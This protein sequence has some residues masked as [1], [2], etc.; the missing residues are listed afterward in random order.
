[1]AR[2]QIWSRAYSFR[3][4]NTGSFC[5]FRC[6]CSD[7]ILSKVS[8]YN[9]GVLSNHIKI[10]KRWGWRNVEV[11][12]T[13]KPFTRCITNVCLATSQTSHQEGEEN[14]EVQST[15]KSLAHSIMT[16]QTQIRGWHLRSLQ[17]FA[18]HIEIMR[19]S[20]PWQLN[21]PISPPANHLAN[22]N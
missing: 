9:L 22:Q 10:Q 14:V 19:T 15:K 3:L 7:D 2:D 17:P 16:T 12:S 11:R 5:F 4:R 1:M 20:V 21:I 13:K 6:R 18:V 8:M